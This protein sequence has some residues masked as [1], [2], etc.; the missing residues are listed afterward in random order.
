MKMLID[1]SDLQDIYDILCFPAWL[2][3]PRAAEQKIKAILDANPEGQ[4]EIVLEE[5]LE[6]HFGE[7]TNRRVI[8]EL[9]DALIEVETTIDSRSP[10]LT[11]PRLTRRCRM[12][13]TKLEGER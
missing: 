8:L 3:N 12:L 7:A 13:K 6:K 5:F 11:D 10:F 4:R 1:R 2:Y 9:L